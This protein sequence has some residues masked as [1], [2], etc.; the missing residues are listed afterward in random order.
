M[1]AFDIILE[2]RDDF[3][4]YKRGKEE[5]LTPITDNQFPFPCTQQKWQK[6]DNTFIHGKYPYNPGKLVLSSVAVIKD[7]FN[8][9]LSMHIP[10]IIKREIK[11]DYYFSRNILI[12]RKEWD[13]VFEVGLS[14]HSGNYPVIN[15]FAQKIIDGYKK[16]Q[17]LL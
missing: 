2:R 3:C 14:R 15:E 4:L 17:I 10:E 13:D 12:V 11:L 1:K 7:Q 16:L 9:F 6:G 8:D 5:I